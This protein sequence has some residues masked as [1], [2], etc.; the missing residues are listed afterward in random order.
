[1]IGRKLI[2]DA[3]VVVKLVVS[4]ADTA[5]AN[6]LVAGGETLLA[7]DVMFAEVANALWVN[8]TR[9]DATEQQA[10]DGLPE[11]AKLFGETWSCE[12]LAGDA[13]SLALE[14]GHPAY[15][16]FYLALAMKV[17]GIVVTTDKRLLQAAGRSAHAHRVM[18][19][20]DAASVLNT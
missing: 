15:D 19:L 12:E 2:L 11:L 1:M 14:L 5:L 16:C 17:D 4:E 13:L 3:N 10:K 9:K 20:A 6:R 8:V 7:P 18:T